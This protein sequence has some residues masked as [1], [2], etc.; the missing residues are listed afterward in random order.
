MSQ[1]VQQGK[2]AKSAHELLASPPSPPLSQLPFERL[3]HEFE[4]YKSA[5]TTY[6]RYPTLDEDLRSLV[7][8]SLDPDFLGCLKAYLP[9]D[10]ALH[11]ACNHDKTAVEAVVILT[12]K[13]R[14]A[15]DVRDPSRPIRIP[16]DLD[17]VATAIDGTEDS[18][19]AIFAAKDPSIVS[20]AMEL[21]Q[22]EMDQSPD[23]RHKYLCLRW[24]RKLA[25]QSGRLPLSFYLGNL[26]VESE[27]I[28]GGGYSDIYTGAFNSKPVCFKV[29]R[30][31][32]GVERRQRVLKEFCHET[33]V[34][35][36]LHNPNVL[37]FL[38]VTETLF[39]GRFCLV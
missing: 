18:L 23:L 14:V 12:P 36:Q 31:F 17:A 7:L 38:G 24:L 27:Q 25:R 26:R 20:C 35:R 11:F 3:L 21:V 15:F 28:G 13:S 30:I 5:D 9:T 32:Q 37:P 34:W 39:P 10:L 29:L 16:T 19:S 6:A 4:T 33:L 2:R 22:W 8:Q 1:I